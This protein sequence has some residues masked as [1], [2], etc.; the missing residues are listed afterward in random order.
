MNRILHTCTMV[1]CLFGILGSLTV[2]AATST[3][4]GNLQKNE[5]L[6][7]PNV[8]FFL[9]DDLGWSDV[10]CFG[11]KFHET[12]SIDWLATQGVRFTDAYAAC[13]VCSATRASIL[14]GKYLATLNLCHCDTGCYFCFFLCNR[15]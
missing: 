15:Y 1:V 5:T 9:V 14:T 3:R 10:A 8:V 6:R 4:R 11:S 12:P 2:L 7:G 13:H